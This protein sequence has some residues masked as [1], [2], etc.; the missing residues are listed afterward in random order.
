VSNQLN[1]ATEVI[2][3]TAPVD[4]IY[5]IEVYG[6]TAAEYTIQTEAQSATTLQGDGSSD[7]VA[8]G[9]YFSGGISQEKPDP[10]VPILPWDSSP[11]VAMGVPP[12]PYTVQQSPGDYTLY[13]PLLQ[14]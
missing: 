12:A 13:L 9:D 8:V 1:D 11:P 3:F 6:Y 10:D 14:R 5:A 4:G 7:L 2:S